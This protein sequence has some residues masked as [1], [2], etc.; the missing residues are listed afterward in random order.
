MFS[1][2]NIN[3][4]LDHRHIR[5]QILDFTHVYIVAIRM[6]FFNHFPPESTLEMLSLVPVTFNNNIGIFS[7]SSK[8]EVTGYSTFLNRR[9]GLEPKI[10]NVCADCTNLMFN[11]IFSACLLDSVPW[12]A[13]L[14]NGKI[15]YATFIPPEKYSQIDFVFNQYQLIHPDSKIKIQTE[16][17]KSGLISLI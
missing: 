8:K 11:D 13:L 5:G 1:Q 12:L 4:I 15:N 9:F 16:G 3:N 17:E 10:D 2:K 7:S 6:Q 14:T